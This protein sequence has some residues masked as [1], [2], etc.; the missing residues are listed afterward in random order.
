M[1]SF[2]PV[3]EQSQVSD[4][5]RAAGE[6]AESLGFRSDDAARLAIVVTEAATNLVKHAGGGEILLRAIDG[7][8]AGVEVL[9]L[10]RGP[11]IANPIESQRDGHSTTGTLGGGLGAMRRLSS[12]FD[13]YT[14]PGS[15]TAVLCQVPS[16]ARPTTPW[17]P[18]ESGGVSVPHPTEQECGDAWAIEHHAGGCR[19]MLADGLGHG[20]L[21]AEAARAAVRVFRDEGARAPTA[22]L[23][24]CHDALRPTRGA[25]VAVADVDLSAGAVRFAGIGNVAGAVLTGEHR[26]NMVSM[27]GTIGHGTI[28]LREFSYAWDPVSLLVL[29]SDGISTHWSLDAHRGLAVRHPSLIAAVVYRDHRRGRDDATVVAIKRKGGAAAT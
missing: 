28:R 2:L 25:A 8:P 22:V 13:L 29:C 5:R 3:V 9:A 4:A 7:P 1:R 20:V 18:L 21:A 10:D 19:V 16:P 27:N 15:G 24:A 11:G 14:R 17:S 26:R 12:V 23:E 6:I